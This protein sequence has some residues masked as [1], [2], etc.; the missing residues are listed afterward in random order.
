MF[1]TYTY[2]KKFFI[3]T[4]LRRHFTTLYSKDGGGGGAVVGVQGSENMRKVCLDLSFRWK[5]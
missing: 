2:K 3:Y 5:Q 1:Y 4:E